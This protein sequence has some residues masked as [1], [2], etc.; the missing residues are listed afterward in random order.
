MRRD[1]P[2]L[3]RKLRKKRRLTLRKLKVWTVMDSKY[4][5]K[6]LNLVQRKMTRMFWLFLLAVC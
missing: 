3:R 1:K 6:R 4:Q 5:R 2:K